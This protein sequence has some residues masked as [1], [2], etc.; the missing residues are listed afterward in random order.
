MSEL[1]KKLGTP[2]NKRQLKIF[3]EL[4]RRDAI[5]E[6]SGVFNRLFHSYGIRDYD[7]KE[8]KVSFEAL[9]KMLDRVEKELLGEE[10]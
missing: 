7:K 4:V 2:K 9:N 8:W 10:K 5:K 3:E 1:W 6:Y